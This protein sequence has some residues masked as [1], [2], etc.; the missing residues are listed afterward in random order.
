M[1][2]FNSI[3]S[4]LALLGL[5]DAKIKLE[6]TQYRSWVIIHQLD[7]LQNE[8]QHLNTELDAWDKSMMGALNVSVQTEKL[9]QVTKKATITIA[10]DSKKLGIFGA[11]HVKRNTKQLMTDITTTVNNI[12]C[13]REDFNKVG[14]TQTVLRSLI[15]QQAASN[16]MN[17]AI[18]PKLPKI[19]RPTGRRLGRGISN[20]FQATINE[21]NKMMAGDHGPAA[22]T[23]EKVQYYEE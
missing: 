12:F 5:V 23:A 14:L 7:I 16:E 3:F 4:L 1:L 6:A 22:Q 13:L 9:L 17:D 8:T 21:Y 20:I 10:T 11:L 15:D 19:G 2:F 18:L